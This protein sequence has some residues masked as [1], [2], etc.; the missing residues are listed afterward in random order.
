[1]LS[2]I[3]AQQHFIGPNCAMGFEFAGELGKVDGTMML[4]NLDG[5]SAAQRDLRAANAAEMRKLMMHA[6]G[7]GGPRTRGVDFRDFIGP[8]VAGK[9]RASHTIVSSYD[10]LDRFHRF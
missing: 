5:V 2:A 8:Y 6:Y 10:P 4:V 9:K 7:A 3:E 1:M